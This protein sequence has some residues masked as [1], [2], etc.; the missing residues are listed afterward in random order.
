MDEF[1]RN[2]KGKWDDKNKDTREICGL[3]HQWTYLNLSQINIKIHF[4]VLLA[5][6]LIAQYI[7]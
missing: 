7:L 1:L 2:P 3:Y 5:L 6:T 4:K